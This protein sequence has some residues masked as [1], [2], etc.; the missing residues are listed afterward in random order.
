MLV[1]RKDGWKMVNIFL[2]S[3]NK[4]TI[5]QK[6][7]LNTAK[8]A[9]LNVETFHAD[10]D[11][12]IHDEPIIDIILETYEGGPELM[13]NCSDDIAEIFVQKPLERAA[14]LRWIPPCRLQ[15]IVPK[16]V[17]ASWYIRSISGDISVEKLIMGTLH[18]QSSSGDIGITGVTANK[19]FLKASSGDITASNNTLQELQF[20][21]SSGDVEFVTIQ[22]DING[23]ASTG[24]I[25]VTNQQGERMELQTSS[26]DIKL[27]NSVAEN[28][29]LL[30]SSGDIG[31]S[32]FVM[33]NVSISTS[34]GDMDI[35]RFSGKM[36]GST[37][38]GSIHISPE[39]KFILELKAGSGDI[40]IASGEDVS[41]TF[42]VK[43]SSGEIITNYPMQVHYKRKNEFS[44]VIGDGK[45]RINVT[46][47]SGE[48]V[49]HA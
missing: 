11:I 37:N 14:L 13:T 3:P 31:V 35:Q 38:S 6:K 40:T 22:G 4:R 36:K 5:K 45:N 30:T 20:E 39:D 34:S 27:K 18:I 26:G 17:A 42:D 32:H 16:D 2:K 41:T 29:Q 48:V 8:L 44:G 49:L 9:Q 7:T 46:T 24:D 25:S 47:G 15:I 33:G 21:S 1:N 23:K 43:T 19:A 10:L 28:G 12:Y